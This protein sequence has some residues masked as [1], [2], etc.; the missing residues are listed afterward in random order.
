MLA[1]IKSA[2]KIEQ[3]MEKLR[4]KRR[5]KAVLADGKDRK[6]ANYSKLQRGKSR[7]TGEKWEKRRSIN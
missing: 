3:M 5:G 2:G 4:G 6:L 7:T 1:S